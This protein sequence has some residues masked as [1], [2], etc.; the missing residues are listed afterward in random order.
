M[1]LYM[2]FLAVLLL[3]S[4]CCCCSHL[5]QT[6]RSSPTRQIYVNRC[7]PAALTMTPTMLLLWAF[8][9]SLLLLLL[10]LLSLSEACNHPNTPYYAACS[11]PAAITIPST[12]PP[13]SVLPL[14]LLLLQTAAAFV[15]SG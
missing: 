5:C 13:F 11:S 2:C 14:L 12:M 9:P 1:L 4:G 15:T 8:I 6:M 10:L 3:T 7:L